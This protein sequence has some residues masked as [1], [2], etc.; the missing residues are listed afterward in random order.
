M[1]NENKEDMD[2]WDKFKFQWE[3]TWFDKQ[4]GIKDDI[5]K[6]V[7]SQMNMFFSG[8]LLIYQINCID[9]NGH[10]VKRENLCTNLTFRQISVPILRLLIES[11]FRVIYLCLCN[12]KHTQVER[13]K[14]IL[15]TTAVE[16]NKFRAEIQKH[17]EYFGSLIEG[18]P[19]NA[20]AIPNLKSIRIKDMLKSISTSDKN[21]L[22]FLYGIYLLTSFYAHG[23]VDNVTWKIIFDQEKISYTLPLDVFKI[24]SIIS[25]LYLNIASSI[26]GV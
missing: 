23:N 14:K 13:F 6:Y 18:L 17:P 5:Q 12:E 15:S 24:I 20:K 8:V 22:S 26:W 7:W 10:L 2:Y 9:G 21:N 19:A 4:M 1:K 25:K 11:Y 16:Y 3:R